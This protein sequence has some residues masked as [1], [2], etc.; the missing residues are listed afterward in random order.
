MSINA[1]YEEWKAKVDAL[2]A[3]VVQNNRL[4]SDYDPYSIFIIRQRQRYRYGKSKNRELHKEY[5][6]KMVPGWLDP[7]DH[8]W[9]I[10]VLELAQ[11]I[12]EN[13]RFPGRKEE[14]G[15]FL[16]TQKSAQKGKERNRWSDD[17]ENFMNKHIPNWNV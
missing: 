13:G 2:S 4:P 16:Q 11:W 5:M 14:H 17:R 8:H 10:R 6:D 15:I 1:N 9:K 3:W 12:K 7:V